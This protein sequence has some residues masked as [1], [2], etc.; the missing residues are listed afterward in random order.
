MT[1]TTTAFVELSTSYSDTLPLSNH[2]RKAM[3]LWCSPRKLILLLQLSGILIVSA[4][5]TVHFYTDASCKS[6]YATIQTDTNV[7]NGQCGEFATDINSASSVFVDNGCGG[8]Y[9]IYSRIS[10]PYQNR[11]ALC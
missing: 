7:A 5:T 11:K 8:I 3:A 9:T 2:E 1:L 10:S 6:L 4:T